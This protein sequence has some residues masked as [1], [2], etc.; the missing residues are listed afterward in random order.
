MILNPKTLMVQY[1]KAL[2]YYPIVATWVI[3]EKC[4][5]MPTHFEGSTLLHIGLNMK[6]NI[7]DLRV[8]EAGIRGTLSFGRVPHFVIMPWEAVQGFMSEEERLNRCAALD[9][10]N[11]QSSSSRVT[12]RDGNVV[13]VRFGK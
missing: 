8:D 4:Q 10:N 2:E 11:S 6:V 3:A 9:E 1:S 7:P 12:G 13:K 5:G